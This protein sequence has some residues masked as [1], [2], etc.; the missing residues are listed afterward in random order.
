MTG[1][2]RRSGKDTD[3]HK[4]GG[5]LKMEAKIGGMWLQAKG[6]RNPGTTQDPEETRKDCA[7]EPSGRAWPSQCL[8]FELLT[9]RTVR[10]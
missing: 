2:L 6:T 3:R 8:D 4:D 1:V 10:E 7:L 5:H 9:S